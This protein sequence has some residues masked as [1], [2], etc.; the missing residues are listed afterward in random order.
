MD[1]GDNDALG[2]ISI[3]IIISVIIV[4][5]DTWVLRLMA[6]ALNV[7][8]ITA[9]LALQ[10]WLYLA[11]LSRLLCNAHAG[12]LYV[13][14]GKSGKLIKILWYDGLGMSLYAKRLERGRF[15]WPSS[16]DGA[17]IRV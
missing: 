11:G 7:I 1:T 16:A 3:V 15:L 10:L 17:P 13:C 6:I 14:R 12:D 9:S 2:L 5:P 4:V 8:A